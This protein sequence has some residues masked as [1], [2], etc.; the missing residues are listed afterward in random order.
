VSDLAEDHPPKWID[1]NTGIHWWITG[2]LRRALDPYAHVYARRPGQEP[3]RAIIGVDTAEG[4][5]QDASAFV[6]RT[7]PRWRKLARFASSQI[8]PEAL[9][10]LLVP[11]A[12]ALGG[13]LLVIEKNGHGITVLR[14]ILD[15]H[16]Y[17]PALV[18]HRVSAE[19][20]RGPESRPPDRVGWATTEAS[21]PRLLDAGRH[22]LQMAAAREC[23]PPS[24]AACRNA[25]SI[26]RDREGRIDLN[27]RDDWVAETLAFIG[28]GYPVATGKTFRV[29]T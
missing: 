20:V 11:I 19:S 3:E 12:R 22:L 26:A 1:P 28:R 23:D 24:I 27:G 5:A 21:K 29:G 10:D 13:A 6:I 4:G 15:H 8:I 25:Y 17:D 7:F 18:Y 14:R 16:G 9:A 2:E